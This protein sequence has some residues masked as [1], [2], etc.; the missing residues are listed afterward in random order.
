MEIPILKNRYMLISYFLDA[1]M[2]I[3]FTFTH[4]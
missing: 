3:F 1:K 4:F 2:Y